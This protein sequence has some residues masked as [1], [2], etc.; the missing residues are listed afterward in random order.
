LKEKNQMKRLN[1]VILKFVITLFAAG[2]ATV[3]T[4]GNYTLQ[5]GKTLRGNLVVTS[6]NATLEE[7]SRVTG[8][9]FITSGNLEVNGEV[10]GNIL[11]TSGNILLG[12]SAIVKG[13]ITATSGN[14]NQADG[15]QV[16]GNIST[17]QS[18][19]T[20]GG[21]FFARLFGVVCLFPLL[22]M[23]GLIFLLVVL[24]RRQPTAVSEK[25]VPSAIASQKLMDL[26]EMLAEDLITEAEYEAKKAEILATM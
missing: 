10:G 23:G 22:L 15:A 21:G 6:G 11:V 24:T 9:V 25:P 20:I 7:A 14:I 19:F 12:P 8:D 17:N 2:C 1:L 16:K 18:T 4:S 5:S 13:N 26:Q 3:S